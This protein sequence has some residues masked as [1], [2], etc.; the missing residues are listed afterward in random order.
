MSSLPDKD[1]KESDFSLAPIE[2][3]ANTP[4]LSDTA[5]RQLIARLEGAPR[6]PDSPEE[7]RRWYYWLRDIFWPW[8]KERAG[9]AKTLGE[10]LTE[11]KITQ[12]EN[13]A[14]L[15][16]NAAA[17]KAA[18]AED[19]LEAA[20]ERRLLNIDRAFNDNPVVRDTLMAAEVLGV[21]AE[22]EKLEE[23]ALM[24]ERLKLLRGT[25][26]EVVPEGEDEPESEGRILKLPESDRE[27]SDEGGI[28][29]PIA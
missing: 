18:E 5:D 19:K 8:T 28:Q 2:R 9:Q 12:E 4:E 1:S 10:R 23:L 16:A 17:L 24:M 11:A 21:P 25:T 29:G 6:K 3:S 27:L 13:R 20:R 26:V 15:I 14:A 7:K 22:H